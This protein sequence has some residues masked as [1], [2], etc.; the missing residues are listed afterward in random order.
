MAKH[1]STLA[2]H[3]G[4]TRVQLL[5]SVRSSEE[6]AAALAGGADII[7]AKEPAAGSLGR[8]GADTLTRILSCMPPDCRFSLAL[9]DMRS[10]VDLESVL[11]IL[12]RI[13]HPAP[14]YLKVGFA[15]LKSLSLIGP[16]LDRAVR[17]A[18]EFPR[19]HLVPVAYADAQRAATVTPRGLLELVTGSGAAGVLVDTQVKDGQGLLSWM[20]LAELSEWVAEVQGRGLLAAVAGSLDA[21]GVRLVSST[22]ADVVGVRGAACGGGRNGR[23]SERRVALL[24]QALASS[25]SGISLG[26]SAYR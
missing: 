17:F 10:T 1:I 11:P 14:V 9:G 6:V 19:M 24:R 4:V 20:E 18:A 3:K 16:V 2:S 5:V 21:S 8:V 26:R 12:S 25:S 22:G 23:V 7:D 13:H 15:G